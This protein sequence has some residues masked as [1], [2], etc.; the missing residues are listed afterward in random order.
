MTNKNHTPDILLQNNSYDYYQSNKI[1]KMF[2]D[3][4]LK[5]TIP[6]SL[7]KIRYNKQKTIISIYNRM[8]HTGKQHDHRPP[9]NTSTIQKIL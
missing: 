7:R 1:C 6:Q 3:M 2:F 8:L 9:T 5:K 4:T